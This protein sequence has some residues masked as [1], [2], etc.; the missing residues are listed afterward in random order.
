[1]MKMESQR[2]LGSV[3]T[4]SPISVPPTLTFPHFTPFCP[5]LAASLRSIAFL[6]CCKSPQGVATPVNNY[7]RA[8]PTCMLHKLINSVPVLI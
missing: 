1:M 7:H 8:S 5:R 3:P 6:G 4:T 2:Q